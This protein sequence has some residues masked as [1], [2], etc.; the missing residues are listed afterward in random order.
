ME[1]TDYHT[2]TRKGASSLPNLATRYCNEIFFGHDSYSLPS[3]G[4][5]ARAVNAEA[6][7]EATIS[8]SDSSIKDT[9]RSS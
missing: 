6:F 2:T 1:V 8:P 4:S 7:W 5:L 9:G 3:V